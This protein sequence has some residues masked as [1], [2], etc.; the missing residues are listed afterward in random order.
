VSPNT[1]TEVSALLQ[2]SA[3]VTTTG[4]ISVSSEPAGAQVFL[5]NAFVGITPLTLNTVTTG[6]H[7]VAIRMTG[8]DDYAV[9]TPVNA[10]AT[11]T[12]SAAL[13]PATEPTQKSPVS[14]AVILAAF[15]LTGLVAARRQR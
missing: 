15:G 11:S 7:T 14:L 5:D 2:P 3:P 13:M 10:G 1:V 9:T 6:S 4:A 8:Y 12:V